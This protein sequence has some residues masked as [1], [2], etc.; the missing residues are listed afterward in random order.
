MTNLRLKNQIMR[1]GTER[2]WDRL[3]EMEVVMIFGSG[4]SRIHKIMAAIYAQVIIIKSIKRVIMSPG[5]DLLGI[6]TTLITL[7]PNSGKFGG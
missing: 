7:R 6:Q 1:F 2:I 3:S 4:I 5:R